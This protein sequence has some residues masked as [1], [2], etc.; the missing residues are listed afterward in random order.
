MG[1]FKK[2]GNDLNKRWKNAY[3]ANSSLYKNDKGSIVVACALTEDTDSIFPLAPEEHWGMSGVKIDKWI[4]SI[5]SITEADVVGQ[6]E[7]HEAMKLLEPYF[8]DVRDGWA[9]IRG[10]SFEEMDALFENRPRE[11]L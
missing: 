2:K 7:Y 4:I 6:L 3:E 11:I 1:L 9:L 10:L 8:L 5:V